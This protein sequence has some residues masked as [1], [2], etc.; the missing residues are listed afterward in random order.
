MKESSDLG[1]LVI[2]LLAGTLAG[3]RDRL[4]T[5]GFTDAADLVADLVERT[6]EYVAGLV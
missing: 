4:N 5:D 6:D 3:L 1:D 2:L